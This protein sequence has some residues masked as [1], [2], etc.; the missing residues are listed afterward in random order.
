MKVIVGKKRLAF[1]SLETEFRALPDP[2]VALGSGMPEPNLAFAFPNWSAFLKFM[3]RRPGGDLIAVLDERRR[4]LRKRQGED[5]TAI[6][7]R[8]AELLR[9]AEAGMRDL[10]KRTG[11]ALNSKE[12]FLRATVKADPLEGPVF[13]PAVV[14]QAAGFGGQAF[15]IGYPGA[16]DFSWMPGLNN[17]VSSVRGIGALALFS[18]TWF[19]GPSR[20]FLGNPLR[21]GFYQNAALA[22]IGFNNVASS[23]LID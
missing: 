2:V 15:F 1:P 11:L 7:A 9:Q 23:A 10:A 19:N 18:R 13:D 14:F 20:V 17:N 6:A 8:Q 5:M 16:P 4:K 22:G 3:K 12:L 21:L